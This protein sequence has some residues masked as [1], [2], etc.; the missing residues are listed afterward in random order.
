[1]VCFEVSI[2][3]P[4]T[5][6]LR[7]WPDFTTRPMSPETVWQAK[8]RDRRSAPRTEATNDVEALLAFYIRCCCPRAEVD[9]C[10]PASR[11]ATKANEA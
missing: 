11:F 2:G 5:R 4:Q 8:A 6:G 9:V 1:M 3:R 10:S 7:L